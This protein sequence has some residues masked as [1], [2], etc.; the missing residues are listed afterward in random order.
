[1][2]GENLTLL[3]KLQYSQDGSGFLLQLC[4]PSPFCIFMALLVTKLIKPHSYIST[5]AR[6]CQLGKKISEYSWRKKS[7]NVRVWCVEQGGFHVKSELVQII[8]YFWHCYESKLLTRP[9]NVFI[10]VQF[11]A[12][13][14]RTKPRSRYYNLLSYHCKWWNGDCSGLTKYLPSVERWGCNS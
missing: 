8:L 10:S 11:G 6:F 12:V 3:C 2:W 14:E 7:L 5:I 4:P 13:R 1:M 9:V